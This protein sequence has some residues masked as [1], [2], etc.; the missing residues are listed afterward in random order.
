V[1]VELVFLRRTMIFS[2]GVGLSPHSPLAAGI[3]AAPRSAG[4]CAAAVQHN[5]ILKLVR[6]IHSRE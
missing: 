1:E 6:T 2:S 4:R 3:P 5:E